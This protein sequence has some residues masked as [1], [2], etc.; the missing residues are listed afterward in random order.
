MKD[1]HTMT[2]H[3]DHAHRP[4]VLAAARRALAPLLVVASLGLAGCASAPQQ[5]QAAHPQDP[6][7]RYNRSMTTF[8]DR[9][10]EAVFK[11]VATAYQTITPQPVRTGVGN[12]FDNIGDLWSMVNFALQGKGEKAYNHLVRFTTNT[13][14][15]LGG[16]ID[17]AT[18]A[19]IP[20]ER[21]DFGLTLAH[22][23]IKPGPYLV[24]PLIGP[25]T[26]RDTVAL[27]VDWQGYVL[28]DMH[29]VSHR[30]SL[31]ALRWTDKRAR[32]LNTTDTLDAVALDRYSLVRD[33]YLRQ[34]DP[35]LYEQGDDAGR[36][37]DFDD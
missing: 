3:P 5:N 4:R 10:D 13:T 31:T 37:E 18:Y 33:F 2:K 17:I 19:Q 16:L 35:G 36:I 29:P 1:K 8:N 34:R 27:P 6:W 32:L 23:G 30:N 15:G 14:L 24:L 20:R 7:E 26:L 21:Q 9:V 28:N 25:S 11:P 22:W 12:F